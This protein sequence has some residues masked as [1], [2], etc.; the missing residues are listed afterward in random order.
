MTKN[1]LSKEEIAK[2]IKELRMYKILLTLLSLFLMFIFI[3]NIPLLV[4]AEY[5]NLA[6]SY[7]SK[8]NY[9]KAENTYRQL[10]KVLEIT[11]NK[12][13]FLTIRAKKYMGE[14]HIKQNKL[15]E[16][17]NEYIEAI[18]I[19]AKISDSDKN[20]AKADLLEKL[21]YIYEMQGKIDEANKVYQEAFLIRK[22]DYLKKLTF[23]I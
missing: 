6:Q 19:S 9:Q 15:E 8:G 17:K 14:I 11:N 3:I 7:L 12:N 16:A 18:S 4:S 5:S 10:T 1:E 2:K 13:S 21:G 23:Y 22:N 20:L